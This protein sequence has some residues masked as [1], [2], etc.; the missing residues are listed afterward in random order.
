MAY[1]KLNLSDGAILNASHLAHIEDGIVAA[2][3]DVSLIGT[4]TTYLDYQIGN[5]NVMPRPCVWARTN[6]IQQNGVISSYLNDN[7]ICTESYVPVSEGLTYYFFYNGTNV[8]MTHYVYYDEKYQ[9]VSGATAGAKSITIP[10]GVSYIRFSVVVTQTGIGI[11]AGEQTIDENGYLTN[12]SG[13]FELYQQS[14]EKYDPG[15]YVNKEILDRDNFFISGEYLE[16]NSLTLEKCNFVKSYPSINVCDPTALQSGYNNESNG[17]NK[18]GSNSLYVCTP[19]FSVSPGDKISIWRLSDEQG[20]SASSITARFIT[21]YDSNQLVMSDASVTYTSTYEVPEGVS[22]LMVT[23][24][25]DNLNQNTN[26]AYI[27]RHSSDYS[28]LGYYKPF[29]SSY[30]IKNDV[31]DADLNETPIHTYLPPEICIPGNETIELYNNQCCLEADKYHVQWIGKYGNAYDWKY[32]ITGDETLAGTNFTLT[33][34]IVNDA[35]EIVDSATTT[36]KFVSSTIATDQLIIPIGDSLTNQKPWLSNIY[37]TLSG[38]KVQFRGTRGTTDPT[39]INGITHEGRSGAGTGWYN[40]GT[41]T[42]TFDNR[43]LSTLPDVTANPFWNT[44]TDAFDFDYYCNSTTDGGA[45]YFQ[46]AS[47]NNISL[48][49]TGVMIFLGAN[50]ATLDPTVAVTNITTLVDLIRNSTKGAAIPIYVVNPHYRAAYILATTSDGFATNS[51][52]EFKFQN[53]MKYYNLMTTLNKTLKDKTN[54][55][56]MP[57][58]TTHDSAHNFPYTEENINPYNST[59]TMKKYTDTIHPTTAGYNQMSVTMYGSIC[60]HCST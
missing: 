4:Y 30:K 11:T 42:Y 23:F 55:Y 17:Y 59:M 53:N 46:D 51:S 27:Q 5:V 9:V 20:V 49:P 38:N 33:L 22:F 50:G 7:Y 15:E 47:G 21:A 31:I 13:L 34:N 29:E 57:I 41:S 40:S 24:Y 37:S 32:S 10:S 44:T 3:Q 6:Y 26:L 48:T 16:K 39:L 58:C 60:A 52:G 28:Y 8:Q 12:P 25:L 45:G 43:G 54:V 18:Y 19:G 2:S 35:L 56:I 14:S 1:E 36:I